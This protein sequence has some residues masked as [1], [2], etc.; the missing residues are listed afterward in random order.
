MDDSIVPRQPMSSSAWSCAVAGEKCLPC[1]QH[2]I[3]RKLGQKGW[4]QM[5]GRPSRVL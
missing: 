4:R 1:A 3:I 5:R 2:S